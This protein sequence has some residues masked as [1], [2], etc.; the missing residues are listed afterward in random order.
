MVKVD[1][2]VRYYSDI[3]GVGKPWAAVVRGF[4][5][6]WWAGMSLHLDVSVPA[7]HR[8]SGGMVHEVEVVRMEYVPHIST[9]KMPCWEEWV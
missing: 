4:S 1:D 8:K 5:K 2:R 3:M 6:R 7:I 9:G